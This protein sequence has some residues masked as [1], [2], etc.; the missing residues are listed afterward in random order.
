MMETNQNSKNCK[1]CQHLIPPNE[2]F[3]NTI[4]PAEITAGTITN[5][6]IVAN[7]DDGV[8][9]LYPSDSVE[10]CWIARNQGI[11]VWGGSGSVT[12]SSLRNNEGIG[13]QNID[14]MN[15]CNIYDNA[16]SAASPPYDYRETRPRTA[17]ETSD[18]RF[19]YWGA[20]TAVEM[21]ADPYPGQITRIHDGFDDPTRWFANYGGAG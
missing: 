20:A 14:L 12:S 2:I 1:C 15:Y 19:C 13:G 6:T 5:S 21:L 11:G 8:I 9:L 18:V 3:G 4:T 16:T 17:S 10:N 7:Q